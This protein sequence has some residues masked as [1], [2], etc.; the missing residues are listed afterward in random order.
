[1]EPASTTIYDLPNE[2]WLHIAGQFTLL[3][4]N[5]DLANLS[6]VSRKWKTV[7]Q[8]WLLKVPRFSLA[9]IDRY[10][11]ELGH[12]EHL[13]AQIRTLEIWSY[14][15]GRTSRNSNNRPVYEYTPTAK[16]ISWDKKFLSKCSEL[17]V[18]YASNTKHIMEWQTGLNGDCVPALLGILLCTL[19]NLTELK[20]G[21]TW[22]MDIP[23]FSMM[24]S[25]DVITKYPLPKEWRH[26]YL[27][28]VLRRLYPRLSVIE[29]SADMSSMYFF[30]YG[31]TVYDF[32]RFQGLKQIGIT[33]KALWWEPSINLNPPDPRELFPPTLQ[34]IYLRYY[35]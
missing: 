28:D 19:P 13:Q 29:V 25:P 6:L 21:N 17:I 8:E 12:H 16:P 22:L 27:N 1:M 9:N 4:R 5:R 31:H 30:H 15:E 10:L 34:D 18:Y 33:M 24:L 26:E 35:A 11:W 2:I 3:D 20:L 23:I 32:R 7:A 14:S